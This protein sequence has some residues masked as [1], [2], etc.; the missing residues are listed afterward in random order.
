MT[1]LSSHNTVRTAGLSNPQ[2]C[3]NGGINQ[4]QH[5]QNDGINQR[6]HCQNCQ[7]DGIKGPRKTVFCR[8]GTLK[9]DPFM[10]ALCIT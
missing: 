1:W 5:C 8:K 3:Q 7:N 4:P 6:Q 10:K 2:H 9:I